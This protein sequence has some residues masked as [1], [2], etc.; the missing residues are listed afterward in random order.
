MLRS[1]STFS[2]RFSKVGSA[3]LIILGLTTNGWGSEI[4]WAEHKIELSGFSEEQHQVLE[5]T[6]DQI[7]AI[8]PGELK[9]DRGMYRHLSRFEELFGQP[10]N[11]ED[12]VD[13]V[14][15]RF[16]K[17]AYGNNREAAI[18]QNK[19]EL[20]VG[21]LFFEGIT[22]LERLYL[23]VHEARH[24]D[25]DGYPH[26]RCPK[27]FRFVSAGQPLIK[28][29]RELACDK[30]DKGAYAYQAAILFELFAYGIFDQKE[31]GLLYNSTVARVL[32]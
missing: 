29:E 30:T 13:W 2:H 1:I 11:G 22:P 31:V 10:L 25:G 32:P 3:S 7:R 19:G 8:R 21:D 17:I 15:S 14:L 5:N 20:W 12:L 26:V 16:R 24:S 6:F 27:G 4:N 23:L 18:N 9:I 28:L